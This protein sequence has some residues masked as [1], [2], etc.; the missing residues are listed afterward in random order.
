MSSDIEVLRARWSELFSKTLPAAAISHNPAQTKWPVHVD[1]CFGRIIL[2]NVVGEAERP[3]MKALKAPAIKNMNSAQLRGCI[4]LGEK[5]LKGQA[6]LVE[7]DRIS[8]SVRGKTDKKYKSEDK[9]SPSRA[10]VSNGVKR[11]AETTSNQSPRKLVKTPNKQSQ[12]SFGGDKATK[13]PTPEE[14]KQQFGAVLQKIAADHSLTPYRKRL[15]STLLSVP[16]GRFTTY[17]AMSDYLHSSAR[18]VGNG[19]RNN[20]F[21]PD[22]PCHRVLAADGTLGGFKGDWGTQGK[23]ATHKLELL[24]KEG[25]KFDSRGK[26]LG[27]PLRDLHDLSAASF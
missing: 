11:K 21:A 7:L 22:V 17:A 16:P 23:Y 14:Q 12:I 27:T 18:A 24:G 1:H 5:I 8:L 13:T 2:D 4:E 19:M 6:D 15:Y 20:P 26:V 3:W 10:T 25:V 9:E